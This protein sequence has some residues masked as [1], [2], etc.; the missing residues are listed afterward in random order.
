MWPFRLVSNITK[1]RASVLATYRFPDWGL[2]AKPRFMVPRCEKYLLTLRLLVLMAATS[3]SGMVYFI[4]L[5]QAGL[6]ASTIRPTCG[7]VGSAGLTGG[8]CSGACVAGTMVVWLPD[9]AKAAYT[10]APL[11]LTAR[12]RGCSPVSGM[13]LTSACVE[14][15]YT[16]TRWVRETLTKANLAA[17]T[18]SAGSAFA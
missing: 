15:L 12:A 10:V 7:G 18:T 13:D 11:G 5:V 16:F 4:T 14:V 6:D 2:M 8:G 9:M 3:L 1:L 17:N